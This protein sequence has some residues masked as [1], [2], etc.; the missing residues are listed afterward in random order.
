MVG[1]NWMWLLSAKA[2]GWAV[3]RGPLACAAGR[4]RPLPEFAAVLGLPITPVDGRSA[5]ARH[6]EPGAGPAL[7][8]LKA[9]AKG[10]LLAAVVAALESFPRTP[11][12][13]REALMIFGLYLFLGTF[14]GGW[15]WRRVCSSCCRWRWPPL[16]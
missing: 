14:L 9:A 5:G 2:L 13:A 8:A 1:L 15:G 10:A 12:L 3:G 11:R 16:F 6:R 7:A 4:P